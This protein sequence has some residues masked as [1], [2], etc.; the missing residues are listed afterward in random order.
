MAHCEMTLTL[1]LTEEEIVECL[2]AAQRRKDEQ[3]MF[4][5]FSKNATVLKNSVVLERLFSVLLGPTSDGLMITQHETHRPVIDASSSGINRRRGS[6]FRASGS[7]SVDQFLEQI[8]ET[9]RK[10]MMKRTTVL[11][12]TVTMMKATRMKA[13]RMS[14][15]VILRS[16]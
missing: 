10:D 16:P 3:G 15:R 13:M 1:T 4:A 9:V 8:T 5:F 14:L 12:N 11:V 7:V 6:Y 2:V